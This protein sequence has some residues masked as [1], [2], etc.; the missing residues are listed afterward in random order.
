MRLIGK[1]LLG[2]LVLAVWLAASCGLAAAQTGQARPAKTQTPVSLAQT[3]DELARVTEAYKQSL[4][5]LIASYQTELVQAQAQIEKLRD[6]VQRGLIAPR[7]LQ[8]AEAKAATL[9]AKI[10]ALEL[11][12]NAADE[13][14]AEM[15]AEA[16]AVERQA[17]APLP[18][19]AGPGRLIVGTSF[20]RF[21]G[22]GSW[23]LSNA[24][25]VQ[26]FFQQKF[27]RPLPI[28]AFGQ[29]KLHDAW[30]WDHRNAMDVNLHPLSAEGQAL[31][32]FLRANGIPFGAFT[33]AIPGVA[34]GPHIHVG[35]PS[36]RMA[37]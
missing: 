14:R 33:H 34:T 11:E 27:G 8:T 28:A 23:S 36:H 16:E 17:N 9:E 7:D 19:L 1:K 22:L 31:M 12:S 24:W 35:M 18:S 32:A 15:L 13:Q 21:T 29:S 37:G 4:R 25:R 3:K 6:L 10:K 5:A 2:G 26:S 30:H 20:V